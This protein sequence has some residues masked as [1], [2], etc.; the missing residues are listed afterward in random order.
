MLFR[1]VEE[2]DTISGAL[3]EMSFARKRETREDDD[4]SSF[5]GEHSTKEE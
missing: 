2:E 1:E 5:C 3:T 4:L